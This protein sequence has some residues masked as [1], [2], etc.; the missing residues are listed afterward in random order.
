M[1]TVVALV[2]VGLGFASQ[3]AR[4]DVKLRA[5]TVPL[6]AGEDV[7]AEDRAELTRVVEGR[8][9]ERFTPGD[10]GQLS[11]DERGCRDAKCLAGAAERLNVDAVV[12]GHLGRGD[13][14]WFL[15]AWL[16]DRAKPDFLERR[17]ETCAGCSREQASEHLA[18]LTD[19]VL[20]VERPASGGI[21]RTRWLTFAGAAA[22]L[23]VGGLAVLIVEGARNGEPLCDPGLRSDGRCGELRSTS[24]GMAIGGVIAGVAIAA[25]V[26]SLILGLRAPTETSLSLWV[27][28]GAGGVAAG[29]RW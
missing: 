18:V 25:G 15:T 16:F 2:V 3:V 26:T 8:V 24:S 5:I 22:A 29:G 27:T 10:S 4:A 1:R 11:D 14:G 7:S 23:A 6:L 20:G 21:G 28:P 19:R 12:G 13:E 9:A 17:D